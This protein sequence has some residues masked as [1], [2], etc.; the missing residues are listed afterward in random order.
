MPSGSPVWIAVKSIFSAP[1]GVAVFTGTTGALVGAVPAVVG[2]CVGGIGF[3]CV[4][5][6]A[7]TCATDRAPRTISAITQFRIAPLR[8]TTLLFIF[9]DASFSS[10][11]TNAKGINP[12]GHK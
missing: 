9:M 1:R 6:C 11:R 5:G 4:V 10:K 3:G 12:C 7:S 8:M 2:G